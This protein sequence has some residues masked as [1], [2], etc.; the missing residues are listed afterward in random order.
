MYRGVGGFE[1]FPKSRDTF[2]GGGLWGLYRGI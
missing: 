2:K 1:G